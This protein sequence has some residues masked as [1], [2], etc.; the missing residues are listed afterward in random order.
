MKKFIFTIVLLLFNGCGGDSTT[1]V[2]KQVDKSQTQPKIDPVAEDTAKKRSPKNLLGEYITTGYIHDVVLSG[3]NS[4]AYIAD[5]ING[6]RIL[7][8]SDLADIKE[9]GDL[10]LQDYAESITISADEKRLFMADSL[11]GLRIVDINDPA[12][13]KL[14]QTILEDKNYIVNSFLSSDE[15]KLFVT[16]KKPNFDTY[17][18]YLQKDNKEFAFRTNT[19]LPRNPNFGSKVRLM[20]NRGFWGFDYFDGESWEFM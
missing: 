13:P 8:I 16:D 7:D 10:S 15:K 5:G 12:D 9:I 19:E 14:I 6:L 20:M 17:W 1:S 18:L 11:N 2:L 3:D 4:K